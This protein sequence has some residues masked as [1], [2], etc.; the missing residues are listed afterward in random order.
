MS[1]RVLVIGA[2]GVL[3]AF[4][5]RT[6]SQAGWKVVRAGRRPDTAPDFRRL[7]LDDDASVSRLCAQVDLVVNTAHHPELV[8][9][10][11]VLRQ[12]GILIDLI[13]LPQVERARLVAL[14][15]EARGLVVSDTGLGGVA[16][17]ALAD[18]LRAHPQA[19]AAEYSLMIS[20]SGSTGR[21]GALFAHTLLTATAHHRTLKVPFPKPFGT[22]RGIEVGA[23]DGGVLRAAIDGVH[24]RHYI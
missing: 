16:Y 4:I 13:E 15:P 23:D 12:G 7:D 21:A 24:V 6:F 5:A 19:D 20:A 8:P 18:L 3:G 17:L 11:T 10:R 1:R 22:R 9:E 2:Q 14:E